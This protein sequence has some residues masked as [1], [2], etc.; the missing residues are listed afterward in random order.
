MKDNTNFCLVMLRQRSG[1]ISVEA[2]APR[3]SLWELVLNDLNDDFVEVPGLCHEG[4][5]NMNLGSDL[6]AEAVAVEAVI[7]FTAEAECQFAARAD[8]F[9]AV[10]VGC[11]CATRVEFLCAARQTGSSLP[12]HTASVLPRHTASGLPG[13]VASVLP[14]QAAS[15]LPRQVASGLPGQASSSLP[16]QTISSLP[17]Q[18]VCLLPGHVISLMPG[19]FRE[20]YS[21]EFAEASLFSESLDVVVALLLVVTPAHRYDVTPAWECCLG[22]DGFFSY[23]SLTSCL[24]ISVPFGML[25]MTDVDSS[26][27]IKRSSIFTSLASMDLFRF[28]I[29]SSNLS[30]LVVKVG[31]VCSKD[32]KGDASTET[33]GPA[34]AGLPRQRSRQ[35]TDLL[36]WRDNLLPWLGRKSSASAGNLQ[37]RREN[38]HWQ[39]ICLILLKSVVAGT[40]KM[41]V[42]PYS[43][44]SGRPPDVVPVM[45]A[46]L[47]RERLGSPIAIVDQNMLKKARM[48]EF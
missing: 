35:V 47:I 8:A 43:N 26:Q 32:D 44:S 31:N 21:L 27:F 33:T 25:S 5:V 2:L 28:C 38:L 7:L 3:A 1:Q 29:S 39:E 16:W 40:A 34:R 4:T 19:G 10:R 42:L 45:S 37:P 6:I 24:G 18:N 20:N 11:I 14:G 23:C 12:R 13:Q 15:G 46:S 22:I 17:R 9:C 30:K 41:D 48:R 36:S